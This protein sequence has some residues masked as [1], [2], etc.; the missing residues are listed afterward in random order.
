M[1]S[2]IC[3]LLSKNSK[4]KKKK[5]SKEHHYQAGFLAE[6][7]KFNNCLNYKQVE[8]AKC[9]T[10]TFKQIRTKR[11]LMLILQMNT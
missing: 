3:R 11:Q 5:K 10:A 1:I 2:D 7:K 6:S 8:H 4:K 9:E